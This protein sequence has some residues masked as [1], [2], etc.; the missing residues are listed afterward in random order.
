MKKL[1]LPL[2]IAVTLSGCQRKLPEGE[3]ATTRVVATGISEVDIVSIEIVNDKIN[4][5]QPMFVYEY[6]TKSGISCVSTRVYESVS[7]DCKFN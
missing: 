6:K 3:N 5:N 1:L 2:I 4:V 7:T